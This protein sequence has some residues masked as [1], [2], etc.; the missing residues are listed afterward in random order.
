MRNDQHQQEAGAIRY[1]VFGKLLMHELS[2]FL[3]FIFPKH[4]EYCHSCFYCLRLMEDV[5]A[6]EGFSDVKD[7][8]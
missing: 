7:V 6:G 1:N 4:M 8:C 3:H 2:F 5:A